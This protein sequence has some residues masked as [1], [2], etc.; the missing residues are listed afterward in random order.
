MTSFRC[1]DNSNI[2]ISLIMHKSVFHLYFDTAMVTVFSIY[3]HVDNGQTLEVLPSPP[4]QKK[5]PGGATLRASQ[6]I[7]H[8]H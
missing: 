5:K 3:G 6:N 2:D 4:P 1:H 8:Y 7:L